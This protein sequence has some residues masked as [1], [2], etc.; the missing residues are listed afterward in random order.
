MNIK[1]LFNT[2]VAALCLSLITV[3]AQAETVIV[4]IKDDMFGTEQPLRIKTGTT[5]KWVNVEKRQYH[6]VWFEKE[7][8][9]PGEYFFPDE[10]YERTFDKP[11]TYEYRCEPH[12]EMF[13][14]IIVE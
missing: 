9:P 4:E 6:S 10:S 2:S 3:S 5:V 12:E 1:S 11:G 7:G 14:T 13:G 8:L